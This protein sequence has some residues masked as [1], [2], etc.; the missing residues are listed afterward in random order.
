[1]D[2]IYIVPKFG[3]EDQEFVGKKITIDFLDFQYDDKKLLPNLTIAPS[4]FNANGELN[5]QNTSNAI[6][7]D[8]PALYLLITQVQRLSDMKY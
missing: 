2:A 8:L 3:P 1:M 5:L 7:K 6:Q 4:S